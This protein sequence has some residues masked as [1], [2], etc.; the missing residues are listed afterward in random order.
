[1][2]LGSLFDGA[3]TCPLA[4]V[5]TGFIPV[6]AS[7]I[8]PFP[9]SVTKAR[10][11]EM[12]HLGDVTKINGADIAPVDLI[13]FG[14][15]CQDLSV[16]GKRA[17]IKHKGNG[18][19]ETTRSGLFMEAVRIIKQMRG[20][21]DGKYPRFAMWEN[22]PGA[23][24]SNDGED[25][26]IVL[27]ELCRVKDRGS[28]VPR[29]QTQ[30]GRPSWRNAGAI[31]GDGYSLAWRVL[32]AQ[33]WGVPQ[34]RRRIFL[35]ADFGGERAAEILFKRDGLSRDFAEMRK[36]WKGS[37]GDSSFRAAVSGKCYDGRGNGGGAQVVV[38]GVDTYNQ[39]LTGS[40]SKTLIAGH[41]D[42]D[43]VPCVCVA[44]QQGGAE[45]R[46]DNKSPTL[47][48]AAGMSGN[49][50][51]YVVYSLDRAAFNQGKNAQ[52]DPEITDSG[53]ASTLVQK[54][55]SAVCYW[56]GSQKTGC[57]T[58]NNAGGE[59]RMPDIRNFNCVIQCEHP[60][61][62]VRR[63]TPTECARLQG[64]P[65]WWCDGVPHKDAPEYKMWGNG[66]ALPCVLY[67]FEGIR[68]MILNEGENHG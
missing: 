52:Y 46:E 8:E 4:G 59:Q 62:I 44:T 10:F 35:V 27:E 22:V 67:V 68:D 28:N 15:P 36:S 64:M 65:D 63:L 54:R 26:R 11:P 20:A 1:M 41:Q 34:R 50:Q 9:I 49:N 16:A 39:T 14:S 48:A 33:F 58:A 25:F 3:G 32:D 38:V 18:D 2:T 7:E 13:T 47:T 30:G 66:M 29:P 43:G 21:T 53:I 60:R 31:L 40:K 45:I 61:Y 24:S 19:E 55:P 12:K 6:W 56:D 23:F 42:A 51:P 37:P 5:I 17:G 57:L